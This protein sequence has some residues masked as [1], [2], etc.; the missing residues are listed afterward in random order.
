MTVGGALYVEI[1]PRHPR[2]HICSHFF[3]LR[4]GGID[5][6]GIADTPRCTHTKQWLQAELARL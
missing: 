2:S 1:A 4:R 5:P 3:E 6:K